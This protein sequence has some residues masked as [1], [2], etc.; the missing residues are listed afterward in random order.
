VAPVL[1]VM[2]QE[3]A[4]RT[5]LE[6]RL[7]SHLLLQNETMVA[8][9]L[10]LLRLEAKA[11]RREAAQRQ[12]QRVAT[13]RS[14]APIFTI[15]EVSRERETPANMAVISS[16]ASLASGVTAGSFVGDGDEDVES[17]QSSK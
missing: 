7:H 2:Q 17:Q 3:S 5:S 10:K 13:P 11:D 9:E 1:V 16:C 6:Q 4:K 15:D 14:N 8:M 12:Q